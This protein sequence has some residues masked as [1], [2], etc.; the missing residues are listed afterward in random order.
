MC[1][2]VGTSPFSFIIDLCIKN[3]SIFFD[4]LKLIS[5]FAKYYR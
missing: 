3:I 2:I 1:L 5:T 4:I